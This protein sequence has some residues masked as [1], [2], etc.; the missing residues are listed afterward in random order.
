MAIPE[1]RA[2]QMEAHEREIAERQVQNSHEQMEEQRERV[3]YA[4]R[5]KGY[6]EGETQNILEMLEV[7]IGEYNP[8][9]R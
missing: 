2:K 3:G 9:R 1:A 5:R 7:S 6:S 8:G 4:M